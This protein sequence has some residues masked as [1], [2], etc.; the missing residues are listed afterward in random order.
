LTVGENAGAAV[1][2]EKEGIA[3]SEDAVASIG[4]VLGIE[5]REGD[6]R[7]ELVDVGSVS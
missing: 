6:E 1:A 4:E 3:L 5:D 2:F 7:P